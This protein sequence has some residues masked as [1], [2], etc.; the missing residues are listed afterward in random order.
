MPKGS[1]NFAS[2]CESSVLRAGGRF[3]TYDAVST[4]DEPH[5]PVPWARTPDTSF[6]LTPDATREAIE[7]SGFHTLAWL[8]DTEVAK[9]WI[10][11]LRASGPPPA[12][13]LGVVMGPEFAQA[14][15]NLGLNLMQGRIGILTGVFEA[16]AIDD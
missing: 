15:F 5:F 1:S 13:N 16:V 14:V 3:A 8:D 10:G 11:E 9:A 12:P 2:S 7:A 4:G 6:L